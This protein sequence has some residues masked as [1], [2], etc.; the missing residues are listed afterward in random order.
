MISRFDVNAVATATVS[1]GQYNST[2]R[3]SKCC[4]ERVA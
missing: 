3:L 4:D 1:L 2:Q